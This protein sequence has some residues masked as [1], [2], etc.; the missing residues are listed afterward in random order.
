[1]NSSV[2]RNNLYIWD[3]SFVYQTQFLIEFKPLPALI[4]HK[5]N[6][7]LHSF[8]YLVADLV[9]SWCGNSGRS[10]KESDGKESLCH[11]AETSVTNRH[12]VRSPW[13]SSIPCAS[14]RVS[15]PDPVRRRLAFHWTTKSSKDITTTLVN[16]RVLLSPDVGFRRIYTTV[17]KYVHYTICLRMIWRFLTA[18]LWID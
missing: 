12:G 18:K 4:F 17:F 11:A 13:S 8:T 10:S 6:Y 2:A 9:P 5:N 15:D 7:S 1:M 16:T 14:S 3:D